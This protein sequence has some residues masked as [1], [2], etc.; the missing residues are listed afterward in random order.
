[1]RKVRV[2]VT[3]FVLIALL[4][5]S[6]LGA[7]YAGLGR[8]FGATGYVVRAQLADSGG[9][10]TNAEVTYRGVAVGRVGPMRLIADGIEADLDIRLDAPKI[11]A[12][13]VAVVANR[14]AVGEQYI[15]LRPKGS[16]GPFLEAGSVITKRDTS[17]PKSVE[18]LLTNLDGFVRSVPNDSLRTVIDELGTAF[19]GSGT[20]LQAMLD[21]TNGFTAKATE[22][23]PQ[24]TRL[25]IDAPTVLQT[26]IEEGEALKAFSANAKLFAEQLRSSDGD[27][28]RLITAA[29]LVSEQVSAVLKESGPGIGALVG[30]L[31]T[32]SELLLVRQN[33]LEQLLVKVPEAAAAGSTVV[34]ADGFHLGLAVTFYSPL[35]CVAGYQGTQYRNGLD[36]GP[37]K[38]LNTAASCQAPASS[39]TNVRGAQNAPKG[40]R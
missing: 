34:G 4:G 22:H 36:T 10:F 21:A 6:Y 9:L 26:Q 30:N 29:P 15:D 23:L 17:T 24:T 37:G 33:G 1:M 31:M 19:Q 27:L 5:V 39:G 40:T 16:G 11:P 8:L 7:R 20:N 13:V 3:A 38:P 35:P 28:R 18:S 14:S 12:D 32:T 2:Q 25:L